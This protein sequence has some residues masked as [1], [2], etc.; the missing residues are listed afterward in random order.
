LIIMRRRTFVQLSVAAAFARPLPFAQ[1]QQKSDV[2]LVDQVPS[3]I[4]HILLGCSDLQKGIA[5]VE[6]HTGVRAVF[7]GVHPGRGTHNAL[8][9]LS[10]STIQGPGRYLEIIAPDPQ[11]SSGTSPLLDKLK[12]LSEPRLVGWAAHLR[13]SIEAYAAKLKQDGIE[14]T[15]PIPGS[16]KRPD[17]KELHWQTLT[18]K[19]DANGL[20]PFFIQWS[21]DSVHPSADAPTGCQLLRFELD[22]PNPAPLAVLTAKLRLDAILVKN[23]TSQLRAV[24]KGPTG[25]LSVT[26]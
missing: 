10:A 23:A 5:F 26:S 20:L 16:R 15:G 1:R 8:L 6:Q 3:M 14:A 9:S 18:L 12:Q 19:D 11:Q 24:I 21:A 13:N 22:S 7:G 25:S 17:G 4:D 2:P